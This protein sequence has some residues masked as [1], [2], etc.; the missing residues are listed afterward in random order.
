MRR[1][2]IVAVAC[3]LTLTCVS[4][5]SVVLM[6]Q[7]QAAGQA[8]APQAPA[9]Q[10]Q[11]AQ[12]SGAPERPRI[13]GISHLALR[14][15]DMAAAKAFYGG[16]LGL[17]ERPGPAFAIGSR[18]YVLIEPGLHPQENERLT[19]LAFQTSDV[20]A[21]GKYLTARGL[22]IDQ[23]ADRCEETAIHVIDPDGHVIEFVQ[24]AWPPPAPKLGAPTAAASGGRALSTRLLH[25]G[26]TIKNQEAADKFYRDVLGFSEIWRGG[27]DEKTI[28][29]INM[30]V[31]EGTEYL[32]YMLMTSPPDRQRLGS[33]HHLCLTVQDI[34]STFEEATRRTPAAARPKLAVP[35]VGRNGRWQLNL[36]DPD[37]TRTELMEPWRIR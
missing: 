13:L 28:D 15:S 25:A 24:A 12:P 31:P 32:E 29:W 33:A 9:T 14:V 2:G 16:I 30:R 3:V 11:T 1:A 10:A 19:H 34:Q 37:G 6:A 36:F 7:A 5:A 4:A 23:P 21:M 26:L 22:K 20:A 18:Q 8:Q 27:R 17:S 35:N